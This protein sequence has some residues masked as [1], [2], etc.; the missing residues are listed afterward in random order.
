MRNSVMKSDLMD[1]GHAEEVYRGMLDSEYAKN[2]AYQDMT[3]L[4]QNIE[5]ELLSKIQVQKN[6]VQT[7]QITQEKVQGQKAYGLEGLP[8]TEKRR[9]IE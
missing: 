9:T 2:L 7:S 1:G 5:K 8:P 6:L 4:S 3:G